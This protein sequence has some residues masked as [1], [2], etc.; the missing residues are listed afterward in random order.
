M[1]L[2]AISPMNLSAISPMNLSAMSPMMTLDAETDAEL[3]TIIIAKLQV[4]DRMP[5]ML[6]S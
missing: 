5:A 3:I 6:R 2:S 1:N 4:L